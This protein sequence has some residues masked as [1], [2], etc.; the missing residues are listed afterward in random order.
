MVV[1]AVLFGF[2]LV[3]GVM[4]VALISVLSTEDGTVRRLPR[5]LWVV[6]ILVLPVIGPVL[7]FW[8]GRRARAH[9]PWSPPGLAAR[10]FG[11]GSATRPRTLAPDDDP[12]FLRRVGGP[13]RQAPPREPPTTSPDRPSTGDRPPTRERPAGVDPWPAEDGATMDERP[14]TDG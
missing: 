8:L 11:P 7:Y 5:G 1:R 10:A 3:L 14:P 4:A 13:G 2:L 6:V 9:E 12:E